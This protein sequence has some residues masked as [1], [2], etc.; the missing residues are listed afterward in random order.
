MSSKKSRPKNEN[1]GDAAVLSLRIQ[2]RASRNEIVSMENGGFK[3]RLT[4]PPVDNAANESLIRFLSE[5]LTLPRSQ[6]EIL[7]GHTSRDKT[8]RIQ[9]ASKVDVKRILN[10]K[11]K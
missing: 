1:T 2:P 9:G 3:V 11:V 10:A 6:I 7:S 8:I 4:A 5:I